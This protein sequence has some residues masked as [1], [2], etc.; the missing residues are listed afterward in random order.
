ML[1]P[2][3]QDEAQDEPKRIGFRYMPHYGKYVYSLAHTN[4]WVG[5]FNSK[6]ALIENVWCEVATSPALA[7]NVFLFV[8]LASNELWNLS[9]FWTPSF[10]FFLGLFYC[11]S[12]LTLSPIKKVG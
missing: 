10:F 2:S 8:A 9:P 1:T 12:W 4:F 5:C 3:G 11:R 6:F 7:T